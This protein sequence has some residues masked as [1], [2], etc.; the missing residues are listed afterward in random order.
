M[1]H[2][3]YMTNKNGKKKTEIIDVGKDGCCNVP[4]SLSV[5]D[6]GNKGD[7]QTHIHGGDVINVFSCIASSLVR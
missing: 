2:T 4:S 6:M 5:I 7:R 3:K 1:C